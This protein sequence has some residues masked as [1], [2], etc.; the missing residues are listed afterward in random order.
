MKSK[1]VQLAEEIAA[2]EPV[3]EQVLEGGSPA[4]YM[5]RATA[6]NA[7]TI[8]LKEIKEAY[9]AEV[10]GNAFAMVLDGPRALQTEF[11]D[12]AF[13]EGDTLTVNASALYERIAS[14]VAQGLPPSGI[15]GA[16]HSDFVFRAVDAVTEEMGMEVTKYPQIRSEYNTK[17]APLVDAVR[18]IIRETYG[19]DLNRAYLEYLAGTAAYARRYNKNVVP[20]VVMGTDPSE[21]ESLAEVLFGG[22]AIVVAVEEEVT[23]DTVLK[24][25]GTV[26]KKLKAKTKSKP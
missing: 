7:A 11:S 23:K 16:S 22:N 24:T 17:V 18:S 1:L 26:A 12:I 15:M 14:T 25:F 20:V 9:L 10:R 5:G 2:V 13:L 19:D 6:K 4:T 21:V 3:A 8:R